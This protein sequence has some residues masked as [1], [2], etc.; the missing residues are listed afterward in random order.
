[1]NSSDPMKPPAM[2]KYSV[3]ARVS[4][5]I[6]MRAKKVTANMHDTVAEELVGRAGEGS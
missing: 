4:L 1:M 6:I 2:V 3:D 5:H